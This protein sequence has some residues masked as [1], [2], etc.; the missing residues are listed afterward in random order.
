[1]RNCIHNNKNTCNLATR[2]AGISVPVDKYTCTACNDTD[3]PQA[4]NVVTVSIA[5]KYSKNPALL[6]TFNQL[7]NTYFNR[8]GTCLR[9]IFQKLGISEGETCGC[10]E[11][12][13]LMDSWGT[14][15][16]IDRIPE[17]ISH[18]NSQSVSWYDTLKVALG[19][20]LTTKSLVEEA[21]KCSSVRS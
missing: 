5:Y 1:M 21:I 11:Y 4:L 9:R 17:I 20:Y 3:R 12:A 13:T 8:P 16:C 15:G 6:D 14:D 18:L 7:N 19:G 10:D 2:L